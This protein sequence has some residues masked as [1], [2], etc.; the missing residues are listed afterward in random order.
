MTANQTLKDARLARYFDKH[1]KPPH[2]YFDS[3]FRVKPP[4]SAAQLEAQIVE[5]IELNG[6]VCTK[7][8]SGG[9]RIVT[10]TSV[11]DVTGRKNMI[12]D[13]KFVPS[14]TES[15]TSDLIA[16]LKGKSYYIEVKFSRGDRLSALQK[17]FQAKV[18]RAGAP[19]IVAKTLED[20]L[21][22][23]K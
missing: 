21:Y 22:I 1:G 23:V 2:R 11:T 20:V 12:T 6:G 13:D 4:K 15:G 10:K 8:Y 14:T 7:V 3:E 9:R 19:Y 18:E 5:L 16:T 17:K